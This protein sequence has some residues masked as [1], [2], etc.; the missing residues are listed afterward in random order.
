[1]NSGYEAFSY[2][3]GQKVTAIFSMNDEMAFGIYRAARLYG[4]SIPEDISIVGFDN[5]PFAD[6]MQVPL[7]TIGVPVNDMGKFMGEKLIEL[8]NAKEM[9][10]KR[11]KV[12]YE[13][14]LLVRGSAK[15][16]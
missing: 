16:I 2:I 13:P 9:P 7:T 14:R 3:L 1:M 4:I 10:E 11:E 15:K 5:V 8:L 12:L 6:V